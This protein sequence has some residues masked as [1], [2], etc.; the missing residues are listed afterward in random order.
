MFWEY[1]SEK[2]SIPTAKHL[3]N[4]DRYT[5]ELNDIRRENFHSVTAK[6]LFIT[7]LVRPNI[8]PRVAYLCTHVT[9]ND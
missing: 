8:D 4:V 3:W 9:K 2:A 1:L 5:K 7:K 6:L